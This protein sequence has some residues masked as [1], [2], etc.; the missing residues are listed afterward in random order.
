MSADTRAALVERLVNRA[1]FTDL[2]GAP[3]VFCGYSGAGYYQRGTHAETCPWWHVGGLEP[4]KAVVRHHARATILR[5]AA[6]AD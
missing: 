5:E 1:A 2:L 4:R 3:C 6:D